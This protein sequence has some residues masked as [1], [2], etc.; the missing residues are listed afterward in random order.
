MLV[1]PSIRVSAHIVIK[2]LLKPNQLIKS[3]KLDYSLCT[4]MQTCKM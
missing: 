3:N 2:L 4:I 1:I